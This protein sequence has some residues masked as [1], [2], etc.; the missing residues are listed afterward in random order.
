MRTTLK[1]GVGRGAAVNGNGRAIYPPGAVSSVSRY[2]QPPPAPRSGLRIL[3]RI[4]VA[5]ILAILSVAAGIAGG[6]YLYFHQSVAAVR[7]HSPDVKVAQKQL[8]VPLP[9][10]PAIALIVGY[11]HRQGPESNL[12]SRSDTIML[13]RADPAT[14]T[15][16]MLSFPRDLLVAVYCPPKPGQ[17]APPVTQEKI[18]GAYARCGS[19][20]TLETVKHLTG[21]SVNYLI[22]V[23]FH[24]FRE[25][26]NK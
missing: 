6:S 1:R 26:V 8:D 5:T 15:L 11:D 20:G 22:T 9:G 21:L 24:G 12:E 7:A 14:K 3:R 16:S 10:A 23:N 4:L 19:A 17:P 18:N 25:I 13:L 2:E